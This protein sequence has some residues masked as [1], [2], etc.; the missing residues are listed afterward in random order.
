MAQLKSILVAGYVCCVISI[1]AAGA[2]TTSAVRAA[3]PGD[4]CCKH[5]NA[6]E[7]PPAMDG[8][9][10]DG[11][12]YWHTTD[13]KC[14]VWE[15]CIGAGGQTVWTN[16]LCIDN[17]GLF[18]KCELAVPVPKPRHNF[19]WKCT[20]SAANN[21]QCKWE[22]KA[23]NGSSDVTFCSISSKECPPPPPQP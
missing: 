19:D 10:V 6:Y 3:C 21:C 18:L 5:H 7:A 9:P 15:R 20:G 23:E 4:G 16:C 11:D 8:N 22:L 2:V 13:E 1:V 12:C 17:P 14:L